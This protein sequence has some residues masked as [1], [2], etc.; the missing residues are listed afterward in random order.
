MVGARQCE[1][2]EGNMAARERWT[3]RSAV[4]LSEV[5]KGMQTCKEGR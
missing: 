5:L 4:G 3:G 2:A 1:R